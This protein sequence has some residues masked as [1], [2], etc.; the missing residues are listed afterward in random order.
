MRNSVDFFFPFFFDFSF[1]FLGF[2]RPIRVLSDIDDSF[3]HSG[4]GLGGPKLPPGTVL[5][6]FLS[7]LRELDARPV[8]IT[9]RPPLVKKG[10]YVRA[11]MLF[12]FVFINHLFFGF[13]IFLV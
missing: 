11:S 2:E 3:V 7:L 1:F 13:L 9:A 4:W 10:T 12:G 5:P 8:F 6:G